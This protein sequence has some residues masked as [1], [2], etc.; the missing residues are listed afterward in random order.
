MKTKHAFWMV[1]L[2]LGLSGVSQAQFGGGGYGSYRGFPYYNIYGMDS[3]PYY[4]LHPPVYY[5]YPVP[6]PYGYSPFAYPPGTP[7]PEILAAPAAQPKVTVN[8]Y[9]PSSRGRRDR[10]AERTAAYHPQV[11]LN[12]FVQEADLASRSP[13]AKK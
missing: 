5:S 13:A 7:T 10:P 3:V 8:P 9:T 12:P 1:A 6:R 2:V 11:I 4:S